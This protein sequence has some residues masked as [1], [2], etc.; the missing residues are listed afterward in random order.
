MVGF[1][2]FSDRSGEEAAFTLM[3]SLAKLM[4]DAVRDQGGVVQSFTGDGIMAVFGAP[5]AYEDA[6]L[7]ACRAALA[8]LQGLKAVGGDLE[9]RH[10]TRPQLR[11]GVN[12]GPAVVGKVQAGS[13][14]TDT[15]N[16]AAR[17][18]T[19][20]ESDS[21]VMSEAT[22]RL[23]EGLVEVT[24]AG[25][26]QIKGKSDA[27]KAYRLEGVRERATRFDAKVRRG[28]TR[29]VGRGRELENLERVLNAVGRGIQVFDIVGE[30]G[31]GKSRLAHEFIGQIQKKHVRLLIGDCTPEGQQ[32]PFYAFIEIVRAAFRL[33]PGDVEGEVVRKLHEGL[34][35][36]GLS[37]SESL[38]LL[39]NLLGLKAREESLEGLD[40]LLIGL[41]TRDLLVHLLQARCR[42]T[43]LIMLIEDIQWLD[44]SSEDLLAKVI[45]IEESLQLLILHTR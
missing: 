38:G 25:E 39:L 22:R 11:I 3:Q 27:L 28:L 29:Y 34:D 40:G 4:E 20:A 18:Q 1:T 15:V 44:R 9:R 35:E 26:H 43:P 24:F 19:L 13:D 33:L 7:R 14:A 16:V 2:A 12:S 17:L 8:I 21:A 32:T 10:G 6:A 31:I 41:R 23:V 5:V 36:L 42:L 45:G 30:P 37:S